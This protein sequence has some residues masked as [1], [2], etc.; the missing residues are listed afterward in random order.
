MK[1]SINVHDIKENAF[2]QFEKRWALLTAAKPGG[3]VNTMTVSWGGLG[4]LWAK[5]MA[6]VVVR[7]QRYTLEFIEA[8][9]VFTLSFFPESCRPALNLCGSQSGRDMDKI[10]EAG[11]TPVTGAHG[12]VY[13]EE[14]DLVYTCK[15][16][17]RHAMTP[18]EFLLPDTAASIYPQKDYH[19]IFF[20]EIVDCLTES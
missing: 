17:F 18:D 5:P 6:M 14:A 19:V 20:G 13:F 4:I 16:S 9:D 8:A 12:E 1:Q 10:K 2:T 15:K 7:P 3:G 11:L